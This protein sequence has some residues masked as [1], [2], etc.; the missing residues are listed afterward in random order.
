MKCFWST[1]FFNAPFSL[2][3]SSVM[4]MTTGTR[5][6]RS[7][8]KRIPMSTC[9]TR[10]RTT[11]PR[12]VTTRE[13]PP[14]QYG[15]LWTSCGAT[16]YD[17]L[18]YV[19]DVVPPPRLSPQRTTSEKA[20][21]RWDSTKPAW[22]TS[23]PSSSSSS[24]WCW[25]PWPSSW[26]TRPSPSS[27]RS[28]TTLWCPSPTKRSTSSPPQVCMIKTQGEVIGLMV[29]VCETAN[30]VSVRRYRSVPWQ[31]SAVELQ[32]SLPRLHPAFS[33]PWHSSDRRLWD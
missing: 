9:R 20:V 29:V 14:C 22:R 8:M 25:R 3:H 12:K 31:R 7:I 21:H 17:R 16:C 10:S 13:E 32:A 2:P 24:T 26:P 5:G 15:G 33:E 11:A 4:T 28:S 23:S 6:L 1:L 19:I 30:S 18:I 27:W